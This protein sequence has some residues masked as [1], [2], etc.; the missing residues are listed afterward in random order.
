MA[1]GA[2]FLSLTVLFVS[3]RISTRIV[4]IRT[5]GW[6]DFFL[7][8]SMVCYHVHPLKP[9]DNHS[10]KSSWRTLLFSSF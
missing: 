4:F 10:Y 1:V 7:V 3:L 2:T 6:D 5:V 9:S 8:L